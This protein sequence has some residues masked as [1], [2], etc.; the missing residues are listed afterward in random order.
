MA[1]ISL[2]LTQDA[3]TAVSTSNADKGYSSRTTPLQSKDSDMD[4]DA[5][6]ASPH[7]VLIDHSS[8]SS[9]VC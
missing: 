1:F 5:H 6:E 7:G 4:I 2:D 8:D 3:S 9:D